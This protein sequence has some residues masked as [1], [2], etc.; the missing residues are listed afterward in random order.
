LST[1]FPP[2]S[3]KKLKIS[4]VSYLNTAPLIWG[5]LHGPQQGQFDLSFCVPSQVADRL[6]SGQADIGIV[7]C[8]ELI[9]LGLE[10]VPDV[11]IACRGPV[12]SI[13]LVSKVE[14]SAIRTLAADSS[15]RTSIQLARVILERRYGARPSIQ[16]M[17][18][19]IPAMLASSDAALIIG[20]PA[21]RLK[22][23]ELPFRILDLGEEWLQLTSLPMVF[24]VWAA[25]PQTIT[26]TVRQSFI[27]SCRF[28]LEHL[29]DVIASAPAS[30][31]VCETLARE[32]LTRHIVFE[33]TEQDRAGL[34]RF[35]E[36]SGEDA[37]LCYPEISSY[38]EPHRSY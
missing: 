23:R 37:A 9:R 28:G 3:R 26:R 10:Y 7:P 8:A 34:Q 36:W 19:D 31:G 24:A 20:D 27:D 32:Y 30:H 22:R 18:P 29:E 35:L 1:Y 33:L 21:L 13:L 15:S 2:N 17:L 25:K 6:A 4:A 38:A 11:G 14:P 5:H 12:R 16:K